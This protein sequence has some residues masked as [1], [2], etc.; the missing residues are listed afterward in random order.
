LGTDRL[1]EMFAVEIWVKSPR[2]ELLDFV[3]ERSTDNTKPFLKALQ[4]EK[5]LDVAALLRGGVDGLDPGA[6]R[7]ALT[8]VMRL[9][10]HLPERLADGDPVWE[11]AARI[12]ANSA[13]AAG[14]L[15]L[16]VEFRKMAYRAM[17]F[18]GQ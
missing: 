10:E 18:L 8:V 16:H 2:P 4:E 5:E 11:I 15:E 13:L 7:Q 9:T 17:V 3:I 12:F 6:K 1:A 14:Q